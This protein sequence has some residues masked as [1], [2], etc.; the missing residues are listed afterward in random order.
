MSPASGRAR[1][2]FGS[3]LGAIAS[4]CAEQHSDTTPHS[5]RVLGRMPPRRLG[6]TNS[7]TP[8][9]RAMGAGDRGHRGGVG[10]WGALLH[11]A[12]T[13]AT[14]VQVALAAAIPTL[15][16]LALLPSAAPPLP[17]AVRQTTPK[18]DVSP[19]GR[20]R[21][22]PTALVSWAVDLHL[23]CGGTRVLT[24]WALCWMQPAY[25][26][27]PPSPPQPILYPG[28]PPWCANQTLSRVRV[29]IPVRPWLASAR[30]KWSTVCVNGNR[31]GFGPPPTGVDTLRCICAGARLRRSHQVVR[32]Y[33]H[34]R[35]THRCRPSPRRTH[36][37]RH[38][39]RCRSCTCS[40]PSGRG[41]C[42]RT[43]KGRRRRRRRRCR[44]F[45]ARRCR[46]CPRYRPLPVRSDSSAIPSSSSSSPYLDCRGTL[47]AHD[48][49]GVAGE[50]GS[51]YPMTSVVT[52]SY[53]LP[54]L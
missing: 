48:E 30:I 15:L 36:R 33:P 24:L 46:T 14:R 25:P 21:L 16:I 9:H 8:V 32:T 31:L 40:C 37:A 17:L 26:A 4:T 44:R 29:R 42:R 13:R 12:A 18:E 22:L 6:L 5:H 45:R 47:L 3:G 27:A 10:G 50:A 51:C 23:D 43:W 52:T 49:P 11:R 2:R 1:T 19:T 38:R 41:A 28:L 39:R 34:C 53:T 7:H 35:P 20:I 54:P